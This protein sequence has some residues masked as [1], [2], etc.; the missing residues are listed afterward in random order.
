MTRPTLDQ[1]RAAISN[2]MAHT[3]W[4]DRTLLT[5]QAML[6]LKADGFCPRASRKAVDQA[7]DMFFEIWEAN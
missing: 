5:D 1:A 4:T 7:W 3:G 6:V 2:Q